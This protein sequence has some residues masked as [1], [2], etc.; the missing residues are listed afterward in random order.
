VQHRIASPKEASEGAASQDLWELVLLENNR[1]EGEAQVQAPGQS[2]GTHARGNQVVKP[3]AVGA[4]AAPHLRGRERGCCGRVKSHKVVK[5]RS[6]GEKEDQQEGD[7]DLRADLGK[8]LEQMCHSKDQHGIQ[9]LPQLGRWRAKRKSKMEELEILQ[10]E[11]NFVNA[12]GSGAFACI[13]SMYNHRPRMCQMMVFFSDNPYFW[14]EIV[15]K[16]YQFSTEGYEESDSSVIEWVGQAEHGDTN[17]M[18]DTTRLTFLNWLCA[19]KFPWIQQ[20]C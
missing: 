16:D 9:R 13:K 7:Q 3:R 6:G 2:T 17:C 8:D 5:V 18:Q 14:N 4:A 19:H 1:Q 15:T 11:L 10:L 12:S 20:D